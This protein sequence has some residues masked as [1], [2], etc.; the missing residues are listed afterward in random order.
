MS[1]SDTLS[2]ALQEKARAELGEKVE[3]RERDIQAL[4][5]LVK[6]DLELYCPHE[7]DAFLLMF[8]RARKF[9][10]DSAA[11]LI[12]R[13]FE[14]RVE[15]E[16]FYKGFRPSMAKSLYEKGLYVRLPRIKETDP[17]PV[18][19]RVGNWDVETHTME[20]VLRGNIIQIEKLIRIKENQVTGVVLLMDLN[21]ITWS[22]AKQANPFLAK[23]IMSI[24]QHAMPC[25]VKGMHYINVPHF[26]DYV[27]GIAKQFMTEKLRNR[28]HTH[29]TPETLKDHFDLEM[30][31]DFLGGK[32]DIEPIAKEWAQEMLDSEQDFVAREK[33]G[34][35]KVDAVSSNQGNSADAAG[36]ITGTFKKLNVD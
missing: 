11:K 10:Y 12:H 15:Y 13:Y 33:Y 26:F 9:D 14:V 24:I 31:P 7:D 22:H 20:E 3:W 32:Y 25:R 18:L 1:D 17:Q 8:L 34:I 16:D 4:R 29:V 35:R 19:T 5:D 36:G 27:F 28:I 30:L 2:E 23:R 21:G 6:A